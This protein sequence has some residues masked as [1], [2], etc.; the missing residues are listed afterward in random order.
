MEGD[1]MKTRRMTR[2]ATRQ[3]Q[4]V[5]LWM[6]RHPEATGLP[7]PSKGMRREYRRSERWLMRGP[8]LDD[9]LEGEVVIGLIRSMALKQHHH[10]QNAGRSVGDPAVYWMVLCSDPRGLA[11]A[12]LARTLYRGWRDTGYLEQVGDEWLASGDR[13]RATWRAHQ[14]LTVEEAQCLAMTDPS[15]VEHEDA[16]VARGMRECGLDGPVGA[17][18]G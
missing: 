7:L 10:A 9:R 13:V 17:P 2:S 12:I 14:D 16:V 11:A 1:S 15:V 3:A 6:I 5:W 4:V 8:S 18:A